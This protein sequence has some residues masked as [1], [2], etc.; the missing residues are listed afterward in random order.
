MKKI[1]NVIVFSL[2]ISSC[3]KSSDGGYN[4]SSGSSTT[5]EEKVKSVEEQE[6]SEPTR[7][8]KVLGTYRSNFLGNKVIIDGNIQ[9]NATVTSFKDI[10]V[11]VIFYSK[12]E[13]E[14]ER[15]SYTIYEYCSP[16]Q[17]KNFKLKIRKVNGTQTCGLNV[18][19]ATPL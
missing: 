2:L 14:I 8:L 1:I 16:N 5:Y 13:T 15:Q 11:E 4:S 10:I 6:K 9:N 17:S 19:S 7:F 12:T 3:G 18:I